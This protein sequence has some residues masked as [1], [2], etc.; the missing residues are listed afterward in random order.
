MKCQRMNEFNFYV[1]VFA[2]NIVQH[3]KW[4]RIFDI[5]L[6]IALNVTFFPLYSAA[7]K[8]ASNSLYSAT[9]GTKSYIFFLI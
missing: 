9:V 7:L 2:P 6:R 8:L 3:Y 5:V 1:I 4:L